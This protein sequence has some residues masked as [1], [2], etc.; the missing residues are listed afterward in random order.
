VVFENETHDNRNSG[1][2]NIDTSNGTLIENRCVFKWPARSL[3]HHRVKRSFCRAR[4]EI[5]CQWDAIESMSP[6]RAAGDQPHGRLQFIW[7]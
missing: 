7:V 5:A 4:A 6:I 2:R 1:M 3:R